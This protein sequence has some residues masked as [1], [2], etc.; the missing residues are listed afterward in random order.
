MGHKYLMPLMPSLR[1]IMAILLVALLPLGT[2]LADTY[3]ISLFPGTGLAGTGGFEFSN[4]G[5]VGCHTG[6]TS[7]SLSTTDGT[8]FNNSNGFCIEVAA[9][10][11]DDG[12]TDAEYGSNRITGNY[13]EG[14]G[15]QL[16]ADDGTVIEFSFTAAG[17]NPSDYT[18]TYEIRDGTTPLGSGT[19]HVANQ[20]S[21]S[22]PEPGITALIALGFA[23]IALTIRRR[24]LSTASTTGIR[25]NQ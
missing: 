23:A 5:T 18:K 21:A 10:D 16:V 8:I 6:A 9:V 11:F 3:I 20:A 14:L 1:R 22:V 7:P 17:G 15:G 24:R 25:Q 13:V 19:Y 2:A 4:P 12:K